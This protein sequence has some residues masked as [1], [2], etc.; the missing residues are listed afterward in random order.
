M[1]RGNLRLVTF[2]AVGVLA[3]F[4]LL[5][6]LFRQQQQQLRPEDQEV[7]PTPH[8]RPGGEPTNTPQDQEVSPTTTPQTKRQSLP[9]HPTDT[10]SLPPHHRPGGESTTHH[11]HGESTTTQTRRHGESTTTLQDQEAG[12]PPHHRPGGEFYH[13]TTDQEVSLPPH[14]RPRDQE[15][16]LPPHHRPGGESTTTP[17]TRRRV[18]HH[19]AGQ[20]SLPPHSRPDVLLDPNAP[21]ILVADDSKDE[22]ARGPLPALS[23]LPQALITTYTPTNTTRQSRVHLKPG[24][25]ANR[26]LV[27]SYD[28]G[29][30]GVVSEALN[31]LLDEIFFLYQPLYKLGS[32]GL[33]R[34]HLLKKEKTEEGIEWLRGVFNCSFNQ[35]SD[36]LHEPFLFKS[37]SVRNTYNNY[38]HNHQV[39]LLDCVQLACQQRP[40]QAMYIVHLSMFHILQL[41]NMYSSKLKMV[42]VLRDPRAVLGA[43]RRAATQINLNNPADFKTQASLLCGAMVDDLGV[44]Y[45]LRQQYPQS[46]MVLRYEHLLLKPHHVLSY[47]YDF[48]GLQVTHHHLNSVIKT[49][50]LD[51]SEQTLLQITKVD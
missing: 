2:L 47:L 4:N 3:W 22:D 8:H 14:H 32:Q 49:L 37:H 13:H 50:R 44:A 28:H 33:T 24:A 30:G 7:S 12:A 42:V 18:Y 39:G 45:Q 34:V 46:V 5:F 31:L 6:L 20:V 40:L 9:P 41:L 26:F 1:R 29:G 38:C 36:L 15:V 25:L 11:R 19:T 21:V 48:L 10:V 35:R 27:H 16:S 51:L 23:P 43:R 17:Q